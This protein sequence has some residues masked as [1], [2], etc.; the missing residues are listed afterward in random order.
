MFELCGKDHAFMPI[1]IHVVSADKFRAWRHK[2][3]GSPGRYKML[4]AAATIKTRARR[5]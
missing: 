4:A 1:E 5:R 2:P 3:C